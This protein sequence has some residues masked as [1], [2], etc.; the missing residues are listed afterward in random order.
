MAGWVADPSKS[1]GIAFGA[2]DESLQE[3]AIAR[4]VDLARLRQ[5]EGELH[6]RVRAEGLE[7]LAVSGSACPPSR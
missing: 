5:V 4:G 7:A 2:A 3:E 6:Q 1:Y